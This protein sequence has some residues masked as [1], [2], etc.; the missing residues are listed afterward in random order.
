MH[1][2]SQHSV[3]EESI[4]ILHTERQ[5]NFPQAYRKPVVEQGIEPGPPKSHTSILFTG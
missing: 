1:L 2:A 4:M 3:R 5:G